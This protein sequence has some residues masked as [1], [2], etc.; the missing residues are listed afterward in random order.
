MI[1]MTTMVITHQE[2]NILESEV[3]WAFGSITTNKGSGGDEFQLSY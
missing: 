3:Q 2:P 1:Q